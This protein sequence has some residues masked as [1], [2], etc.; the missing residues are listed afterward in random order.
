MVMMIA[1]KALPRAPQLS[2]CSLSPCAACARTA[3]M[4]ATRA[5]SSRRAAARTGGRRS[6]LVDGALS[7][8]PAHARF[9]LSQ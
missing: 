9:W 1:D 6:M 4:A 3:V 7:R 2:S 8:T 5:A